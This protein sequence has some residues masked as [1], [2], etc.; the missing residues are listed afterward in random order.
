MKMPFMFCRIRKCTP[1][2]GLKPNTKF[3]SNS[4]LIWV[5][6]LADHW[7]MKHYNSAWM[8]D[9]ILGRS[10]TD[11]DLVLVPDVDLVDTDRGVFTY[12]GPDSV[13]NEQNAM[14]KMKELWIGLEE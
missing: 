6:M 3:R 7:D 12:D 5:V 10:E 8:G 11:D 1:E 13:V 9:D 4:H 2:N 14:R